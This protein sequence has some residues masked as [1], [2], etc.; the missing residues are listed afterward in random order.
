M[1]RFPV[2]ALSRG[3][4][5]LGGLLGSAMTVLPTAQAS[6]DAKQPALE[7]ARALLD[8]RILRASER[9]ERPVQVTDD[10][11][12]VAQWPNWPNYWRSWPN[13]RN[14]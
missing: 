4:I 1:W 9:L 11:I 6:I 5:A 13:W 14:F 10:D 7:Q 8:A 3:V 2:E 12:R